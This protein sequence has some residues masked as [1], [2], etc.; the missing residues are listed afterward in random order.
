MTIDEFINVCDR[1]TNKSLF[2]V[3]GAGQLVRD[4]QGNL[5]RIND[6]NPSEVT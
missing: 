2:Q 3:N 4:Q 5:T 6:D 1:F